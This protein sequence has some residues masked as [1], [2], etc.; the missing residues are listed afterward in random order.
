MAIKK[1]TKSFLD[2]LEEELPDI[3]EEEIT[4][5]NKD[6]FDEVLED[7]QESSE[8][9][10]E[11]IDEYLKTPIKPVVIEPKF[12]EKPDQ[13]LIDLNIPYCAK[14][15]EPHSRDMVGNMQCTFNLKSGCPLLG[16]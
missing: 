10:S 2:D 5:E 15:K 4:V 1:P 9:L 3:P 8:A 14:C 13:Y 11:D 6:K 7:I 12:K 16:N